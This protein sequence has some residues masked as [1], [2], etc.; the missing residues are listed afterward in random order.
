M[1]LLLQD[2]TLW[3]NKYFFHPHIHTVDSANSLPAPLPV[4]PI[5]MWPIRVAIQCKIILTPTKALISVLHQIIM[6]V[7]AGTINCQLA[8]DF[9]VRF[10][11]YLQEKH[12]VPRPLLRLTL[13]RIFPRS[14]PPYLST[15]FGQ[16]VRL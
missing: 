16:W 8:L 9:I 7:T 4:F 3:D 12:Q 1:E 2:A 5:P 11:A 10:H 13:F 6:T 14:Y 15:Q